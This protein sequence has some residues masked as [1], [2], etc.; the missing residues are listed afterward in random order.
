MNLTEQTV[1]GNSSVTV[2]DSLNAALLEIH[3][4]PSTNDANYPDDQEIYIY[5]DKNPSSNPS[6]ERKQ[7]VFDG[8]LFGLTGGQDELVQELKIVNN[9]PVLSCYVIRRVGIDQTLINPHYLLNDPVIEA[10]DSVD[11]TLFEGTNYI[12]SN[13]PDAEFTIIYPKATASN[14][15]YVSALNYARHKENAS[16]EFSLDDIYFKDAFTKTGNELNEEIDNLN[17]KCITSKNNNFSLDSQGNLIVN[18]ITTNS[19]NGLLDLIYPVGSIYMS[20]NSTSPATLF[21]GTWERIKSKFLFG[22]EDNGDY[23]NGNVGGE[24]EH[25]LL[26]NEMPSHGHS[27][28][29]VNDGASV[30]N[31]MGQYPIRI[32]Q[33]K[34]NNWNG[35]SSMI[36]NTG[37]GQAHNNM[38]PYLCVYVWKRIS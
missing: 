35:T 6:N 26:I 5:V 20:V 13:Y 21:G 14:K 33:D 27:W 10:R 17:V 23:I 29:G 15:Y 18:S 8:R 19:T 1:T 11:I 34:N 12:Y 32:Y 28:K 22:C 7:Y 9:E 3:M 30:T 2:N 31:Q 36:N 25:Q 38:P 24:F 37:G 4:R 16:D